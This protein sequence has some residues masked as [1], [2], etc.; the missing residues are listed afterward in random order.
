MKSFQRVLFG[1]FWVLGFAALAQPA[2]AA[3]V[4]PAD[5]GTWCRLAVEAPET[6]GPFA[7]SVG[8][9]GFGSTVHAYVSCN[10]ATNSVIVTATIHWSTNEIGIRTT[11][12]TQ[13]GSSHSCS[14][15]CDAYA[16]YT[17]SQLHCG[18]TYVYTDYGTASATYKKTSS[19]AAVKL[20]ATGGTTKGSSHFPNPP[21][22]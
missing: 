2:F 15:S 16:Y 1:V 3:P 18:E 14:G 7:D 5:P 13:L 4:V 11:S 22:G 12:G 10:G 8:K 19:S 20:T 9:Y 21:C 17:R 6:G